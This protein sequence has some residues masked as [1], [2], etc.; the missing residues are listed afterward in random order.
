M[1][2]PTIGPTLGG[3]D[4]R[5]AIRGA[6]SSSSAPCRNSWRCS[7][8]PRLVEDPPFLR[9][10]KRAGVTVDFIGIS[11]LAFG[12]RL[13]QVVLDK[14]QEDDWFGSSFVTRLA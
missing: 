1:L 11:L 4:S 10:T 5:I 13:V 9:R 12:G 8:S 2:A 7:W 14:G 6:G 3:W